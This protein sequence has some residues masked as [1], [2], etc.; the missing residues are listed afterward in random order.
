[1]MTKHFI[2]ILEAKDIFEFHKNISECGLFKSVETQKLTRRYAE[3]LT[4]LQMTRFITF[5]KILKPIA[6]K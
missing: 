6:E 3:N 4:S 5:N 2:N 1:M